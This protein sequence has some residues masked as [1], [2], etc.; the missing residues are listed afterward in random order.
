MKIVFA[1]KP[2]ADAVKAVQPAISPSVKIPSLQSIR[3][4]VADGELTLTAGDMEIEASAVIPVETTDL[5]R[6]VLIQK[7]MA[8]IMA[9]RAAMAPEKAEIVIDDA[10]RAAIASHGR[11]RVELPVL[12]GE[13]FPLFDPGLADWSLTIR[14]HE[15]ARMIAATERASAETEPSYPAFEGALLHHVGEELRLTATNRNRMHVASASVPLASGEWP[16]NY[17]A[18]LPGV[19]LPARALREMARMLGDAEN[20]VSLSGSKNFAI[21]DIG[22]ARLATKLIA[23]PFTDYRRIWPTDDDRRIELAAADLERA[24]DMLTRMPAR[25]GKGQANAG[26]SL[27]LAFEN[28]GVALTLRGDGGVAD[29]RVDAVISAAAKGTEIAV[30]PTYLRD[31]LRAIGGERVV[32]TGSSA[33]ARIWKLAGAGGS[34]VEATMAE[35]KF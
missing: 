16:D 10:F 35:R 8:K 28:D 1:I 30:E 32:M 11:A 15:L 7:A 6:P 14:A 12:P 34:T 13:D 20:E 33:P 18:G 19:T 23:Y 27:R 2:F 25:A 26:R 5:D 9:A 17:G 24:I 31:A 4:A 29:D 3:V 21:L 22:R